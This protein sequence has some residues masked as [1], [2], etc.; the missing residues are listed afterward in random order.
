MF[1]LTIFNYGGVCL[2][3]DFTCNFGKPK[4]NEPWVLTA[5]LSIVMPVQQ[6]K[7]RQRKPIDV[8]FSL[9]NCKVIAKK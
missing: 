7:V 3:A 1:L 2:K 5:L 6:A 8:V 9:M 4:L